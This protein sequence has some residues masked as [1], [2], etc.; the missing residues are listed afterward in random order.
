[1]TK[2]VQ[3]ILSWYEAQP[4]AVR[5][6][7]QRILEHGRLGGTGRLVILPVDQGVE[8]GPDR[9]FAANPAGYD[10]LY[11][12]KLAVEAGCS[13][14]AAPLGALEM[15]AHL[16]ADKIPLILKANGSEGLSKTS[17]AFSTLFATVDDAVRLGCAAIGYTIYPGSALSPQMYQ[18]LRHLIAEAR[19]KG[20]VSVVWAY[21]RG[22]GLPSKEAETAID[23]VS[24]AAHLSCQLG[25][26]IVKVKLP[27]SHVALEVN[28]KVYEKYQIPI[29][30]LT[31]RVKHVVQCA[32]NG[33]RI[34]IFSGVEAKDEQAV[35]EEIKAVRDGGGFGS[36][37]GRN[38]FQRPWDDA[39]GFLGKVMAI[40]EK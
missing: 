12:F 25:A 31:E 23:I 4:K 29:S 27:S 3:E 40:Y 30:T 17:D 32:F 26:H 16:Y 36:I 5:T 28:Q 14:H 6:N 33:Q 8:H 15:G 37:I 39:V 13:A 9:S 1:M 10:P 35:L 7:L 11:H 18:I 24:Y 19:S 2:R 22:S 34:V 20:L 21:P 38:S